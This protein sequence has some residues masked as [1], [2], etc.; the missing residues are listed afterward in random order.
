MELLIFKIIFIILT[1]RIV[2]LQF[3]HCLAIFWDEATND[4]VN[5]M[6]KDPAKYIRDEHF[7]KLMDNC[8][9]LMIFIILLVAAFNGNVTISNM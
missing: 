7:E 5:I 1:I 9:W 2:F 4:L 8:V 6:M 3:M